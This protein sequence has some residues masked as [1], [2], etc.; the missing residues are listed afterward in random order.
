MNSIDKAK[1]LIETFGKE[2]A[3]KVAEEMQEIKSVYHDDIL[4]DYWE[5]VKQEIKNL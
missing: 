4:Y 3:L 2:F 5:E 1:K